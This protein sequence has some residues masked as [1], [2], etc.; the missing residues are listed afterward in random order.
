VRLQKGFTRVLPK[1]RKGEQETREGITIAKISLLIAPFLA[2]Y[3][4]H[5]ARS[6]SAKQRAN[7]EVPASRRPRRKGTW[8][9][10]ISPN[11]MGPSANP[12]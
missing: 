11:R 1:R 3:N 5:C 7:A 2:A 10:L 6:F 9:D 4:L 12:P 8:R